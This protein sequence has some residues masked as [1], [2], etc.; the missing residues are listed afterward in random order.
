MENLKVL[1][2]DKTA[3]KELP[4]SL[5]RL[6]GLEELSLQNCAKLK[7]IP[8]SLGN[9][10]ELLKLHL[11]YC[12]SLETFPSSIFKLK[13]TELHF[14]GCSMLQTFSEIPNECGRLS[15]L[16]EL[17]LPGSSIA[18]LPES[19][20]H[21]S[22]LRSLI[23]SDCKL[24]E[25]V[26]KLPPNL[27][28]VM[29]FDCP[30]IKRLMLNSRSA[31]KESFFKFNLTSSQELDATSLS[32]IEEEAYIKINDDA[33]WWVLFCFA[34]NAVPDWF[35]HRCQGHSKTIRNDHL[36][37]YE[38]NRLVGFGLCVVLGRD[39]PFEFFPNNNGFTYKLKFESDD[40]RHFR[41]IMLAVEYDW[42]GR[43]RRFTQH[44][45]FLWKFEMDLARIGNRLFGAH[46]ITFE[47]LDK[48][49]RPLCFPLTMT[50]KECGIF[51]L[52]SK[53]NDDDDDDDDDGGIEGACWIMD[54]SLNKRQ[55]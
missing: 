24:L 27:I 46:T 17:S 25:C 20:A 7:T 1:I 28:Q 35:T 6:V 41:P 11:N 34:G 48:H 22:S 30:S 5:Y 9:L 19:M 18:N 40:Q 31:S 47:I 42:Q 33:Y 39:F 2:L 53:E 38:G 51:P 23:I 8:S 12:K 29:A 10:S 32:N 26:P 44:H 14:K 37:L 50:V 13:L 16:T 21:L 43:D 55:K 52:Y 36:S 3:I 49:Y 4:S 45:T 54:P 15:S